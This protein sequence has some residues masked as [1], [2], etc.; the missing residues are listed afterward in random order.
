MTRALLRCGLVAPALFVASFLVQGAVRPG[1]DPLRHA[2]STL[3]LGP[4]GGWQ[5]AT[6]L[7]TGVLFVAFA[8]GVRRRVDGRWPALLIALIGVGFVGAGL[9]ACD[10]LSGYPPG[11]PAVVPRS[12]RGTLHNAFS[13]LFFLGLP[14]AC[15]VAARRS[16]LRWYSVATAAAFLACFVVTTV[17]FAQVEPLVAVGGLLQRITIVVG[18]AWLACVA[19]H[20]STRPDLPARS[21]GSDRAPST[22]AAA[23]PG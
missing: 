16:V 21:P 1:Y 12:V 14:A 5:A 3:S 17:A 20:L 2:V 23:Q 13:A 10:P 8:A 19:V 11:P 9:F 7:A 22:G 15:L 4:G 6:F 18:F